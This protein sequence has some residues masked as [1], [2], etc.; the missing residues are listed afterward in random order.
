M[1]P[2]APGRTLEGGS[3]RLVSSDVQRIGTNLA[4]TTNSTN[5]SRGTISAKLSSMQAYRVFDFVILLLVIVC[6]AMLPCS[7]GQDQPGISSAVATSIPTSD[8]LHEAGWWPTK[9][10][11]PRSDYAGTAACAR[12]HKSI[13]ESYNDMAMSHA[14]ERP[15]DS[16]LLAQHTD[17]HVQ[18][19]PYR[20][21]L[22]TSAGKSTYSVTDGKQTISHQLEW[23]FGA[24]S[25]GQTYV[26]EQGDQFYE[27]HV[28]FYSGI[29]GLDL[30]T[31]HSHDV[32]G[33]LED[34]AGR[35]MYGPET[36]RCFACHTTEPFNAGTFDPA[37]LANGVTCEA[38]H[39]PAANHVAAERAGMQEAASVLLN[40]AKLDRATAVDFCGACHRTTGDVIEQGWVDIGVMNTR[41]QPYRLQKS[42]CW[43]RGDARITCTSCHDPHKPLAHEAASY[44]H[45]CLQCHVANGETPMA[46]KPGRACT[47]SPSNCV[48]CHMPKYE[49]PGAHSKFS[50]HYIRIVKSGEAYPN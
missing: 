47:V 33:N 38:C 17:L 48:N 26:F 3:G 16:G 29:A 42:L 23:A 25:L 35:H 5:R 43:E 6:L 8:R 28:S 31:G 32:P 34:A 12:C 19:G 41:F 22:T 46:N 14:S 24:G 2:A 37:G 39:G 10:D 11:A 7:A 45:A 40:P 1:P 49:L 21:S 15:A 4:P 18:L 20:Y 36:H 30:T 44:D 13:V 50:D 9:I 27:S